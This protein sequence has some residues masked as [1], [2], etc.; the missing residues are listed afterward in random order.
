VPVYNVS[1]SLLRQRFPDKP[2]FRVFEV[3]VPTAP[4]PG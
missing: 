1:F 2:P 4:A 3:A